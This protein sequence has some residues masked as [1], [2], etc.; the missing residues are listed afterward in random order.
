MNEVNLL[1]EYNISKINFINIQ[2]KEKI[3]EGKSGIIYKI[4]DNLVIKILKNGNRFEYDFY[5][6]F[7]EELKGSSIAKKISLPIAYGNLLNDIEIDNEIFNMKNKFL[8][9]NK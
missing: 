8:I 7:I 5:N 6:N 4:S 3:G 2:L 1:V 9:L